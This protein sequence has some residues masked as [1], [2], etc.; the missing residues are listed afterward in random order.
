MENQTNVKTLSSVLCLIMAVFFS[1][2]VNQLETD[3]VKESNIP[4]QFAANVMQTTSTRVTDAGFENGDKIGLFATLNSETL[5]TE[6]YIDN[7]YM[8]YNS[9]LVPEQMVFY[10]EGKATLNFKA[11]YPY[12]PDGLP[13]GSSIL[14]IS[15]QSDQSSAANRSASDFLVATKDEV[16]SSDEVVALTFQ[17]RLAKL[18]IQLVPEE[19][20]NIE[21]MLKA[22]P[23]VVASGF[24]TKADYDLANDAI[25]NKTAAT[26]II[27]SGEWKEE[28]GS[29]VGK[30]FI[31]IPQDIDKEKQAIIIEWNGGIYICKLDNVSLSSNTQRIIKIALSKADHTLT[32]IVGEIEQWGETTT[33]EDGKGE[34]LANEIHTAAFSF[35]TSSIYR[36]YHDGKAVAEVCREYLLDNNASIA[37]QAI[38]VYPVANEKTVLTEGTVLQLCGE[39]QNLHGGQVSWNVENNTLTYKAGTSAPI[40]KFRISKDGKILLTNDL[41][42]SLSV[43]ISSYVL[44]DIRQGKVQTYA[45]V[46]IGSQYWMR[47]ELKATCYLDGTTIKKQDALTAQ[48]GAG[49]FKPAEYDY[50]F[51]SGETLL[52]GHNIAPRGWRVPQTDD[53]KRL[54]NYLNDEAALLKAGTWEVLSSLTAPL[55]SVSNLTDFRAYPRGIW[56]E[57]DHSSHGYTIAYWTLDKGESGMVVPDETVFLTADGTKFVFTDSKATDKEYLKVLSIRCIQE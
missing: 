35:E 14:P 3:D 53:W 54:Q 57:K 48:S 55:A 5:L 40:E 38:V 42:E 10:P 34:I 41:E 24:Y 9:I 2:C 47:E 19:G 28:N 1:A 26:D 37:S 36:I 51:Y 6:R 31:V 7:L 49:Y 12:Q 30:E 44:R 25:S 27:A 39:K 50:Y 45:M 20:E 8:E 17:H 23:K 29:L 46:K 21:E 56:T 32:G 13:E 15:I 11:Y 33:Q 18:R 43:N 52:Q 4:I 22:N 16:S